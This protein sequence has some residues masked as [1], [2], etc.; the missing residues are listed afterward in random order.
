MGLL[1]HF[2]KGPHKK[3]TLLLTRAGPVENPHHV[4]Y[5]HPGLP[6]AEEGRK[7]LLYH[8]ILACAR[9]GAPV[10][11]PVPACAG[12]GAP[13]DHLSLACAKLGAL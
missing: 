11:H 4:L 10:N 9:M 12:T 13:V 1:G 2:L 8:P 6:L 5:S 7:A 3:T